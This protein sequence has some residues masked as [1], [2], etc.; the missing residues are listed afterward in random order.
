MVFTMQEIIIALLCGL[1]LGLGAAIW[2]L[3]A[4]LQA[5]LS[6]QKHGVHFD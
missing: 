6:S 5:W 4:V 3:I 2:L 1:V